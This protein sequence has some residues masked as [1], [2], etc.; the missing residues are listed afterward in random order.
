METG[1][2]KPDLPKFTTKEMIS[3][4]LLKIREE[5]QY[6]ILA[7]NER[8][9]HL[10]LKTMFNKLLTDIFRHVKGDYPPHV[11]NKYW[12][13]IMKLK[14]YKARC[15]Y[16]FNIIKSIIND[17]EF[18]DIVKDFLINRFNQIEYL[19]PVSRQL[20]CYLALFLLYRN[21]AKIKMKLFFSYFFFKDYTDFKEGKL[22]DTEEATSKAE[23]KHEHL[24]NLIYIYI[25]KY[26]DKLLFDELEFDPKIYYDED[27]HYQIVPAKN[28]P[29]YGSYFDFLVIYVFDVEN[30]PIQS[31]KIIKTIS[32]VFYKKTN[33]EFVDYLIE[34]Y[35]IAIKTAFENDSHYEYVHFYDIMSFF[36]L[37]SKLKI[38]KKPL[39]F[40][41][42]GNFLFSKKKKNN[43]GNLPFIVN[44]QLRSYI[45]SAVSHAGSLIKCHYDNLPEEK[46]PELIT[47]LA[48]VDTNLAE[49]RIFGINFETIYDYKMDD[50]PVDM[51]YIEVIIK[52]QYIYYGSIEN[53][54]LLYKSYLI[55]DD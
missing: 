21:D 54:K 29:Y 1:V 33:H 3:K 26:I 32:E 40:A 10:L 15:A 7:N 34:S 31:E 49:C 27:F 18:E 52:F 36:N 38:N 39:L 23:L 13:K 12:L 44:S 9:L 43:D 46:K 45:I 35:I 14:S 16:M 30:D 20:F 53:L 2:V 11:I 19:F 24:D 4:A 50:Y 22:I 55:S 6:V 47:Q 8:N 37:I 5:K 17:M 42:I 28:Q 41:R 51:E 25:C 48:A